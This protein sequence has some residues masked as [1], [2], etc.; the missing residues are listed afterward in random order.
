MGRSEGVHR[1]LIFLKEID[2][3]T[4][5]KRVLT[6]NLCVYANNL[7]L[8]NQIHPVV[9]ARRTCGEATR[10]EGVDWILERSIHRL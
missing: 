8:I 4:T 7:V 6:T 5:T 2:Q 10:Q 1:Q 3:R 9:F